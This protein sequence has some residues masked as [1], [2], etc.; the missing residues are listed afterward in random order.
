[1]TKNSLYLK[2]TKQKIQPSKIAKTGVEEMISTGQHWHVV[3]QTEVMGST[4]PWRVEESGQSY[5]IWPKNT[6]K[7]KKKKKRKNKQ[8]GE[9]RVRGEK[10]RGEAPPSSILSSF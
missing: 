9:G 10:R 6:Y 2:Q 8:K 7:K 3:E 1:L 4:T 5:C